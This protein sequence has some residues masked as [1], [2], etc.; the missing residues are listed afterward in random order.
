[1]PE[2]GLRP[3][4]VM[5]ISPAELLQRLAPVALPSS[6]MPAALAKSAYVWDESKGID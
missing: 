6:D 5:A 1:M 2:H 4:L 3:A